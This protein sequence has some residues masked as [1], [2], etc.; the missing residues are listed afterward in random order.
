MNRFKRLEYE[1][2]LREGKDVKNIDKSRCPLHNTIQDT[3]KA[4]NEGVEF[5]FDQIDNTSFVIASHNRESVEKAAN[6]M[7]KRNI[8]PQDP[9]VTFAQLYGMTNYLSLGL[10]QAGYNITKYL[11]YGPLREVLPYLSRRLQENADIMS[12]NRPEIHNLAKEIR[13]RLIGK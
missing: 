3:H 5:L 11:P 1:R 12:S 4:Y 10:A 7:I 6:Q 9:R 8:R 13:R 2:L